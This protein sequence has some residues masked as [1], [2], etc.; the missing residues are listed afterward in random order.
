MQ[1]NLS[2]PVITEHI[3]LIDRQVSLSFKTG[4]TVQGT[5]F[6]TFLKFMQA[7]KAKLL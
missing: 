6:S 4:S 5:R 1:F 7:S 2:P 3:F